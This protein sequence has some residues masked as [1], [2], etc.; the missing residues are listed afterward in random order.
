MTDIDQQLA[1]IANYTRYSIDCSRQ[2]LIQEHIE[3]IYAQ[4]ADPRNLLRFGY[5][6]Y[7]QNYEDGIIEEIFSR[8]GTT[9][10]SFVEIGAGDGIENNTH[11]LLIQGWHGHWI[12]AGSGLME[13]ANQKHA[14]SINSGMLTTSADLVTNQNVEAV[15]VMS[16]VP[17]E[18]D[19][20]VIDVDGNDYYI[21]Q[22]IDMYQPRVVVVEYNTSLGP[23]ASLVMRPNLQHVWG[24]RNN[25]GASLRAIENLGEAK[26]Y[27]LVCCDVTGTN[28]FFVRKDLGHDDFG[29]QFDDSV[30]HYQ[31]VRYYLVARYGH[32]KDVG[33]WL[34]V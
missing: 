23:H 13:Q 21:W 11:F 31:P 32:K 10:K 26:G 20:L 25:Y 4:Y 3:R 8:I 29:D 22:A 34:S 28:A 1:Q 33:E 30:D 19:L 27:R 18:P 15:F 24:G 16:K 5:Q 17:K 7:S 2:I 12:D 9:D 14:L 6:V